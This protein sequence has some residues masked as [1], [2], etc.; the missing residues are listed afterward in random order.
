MNCILADFYFP[1]HIQDLIYV[2]NVLFLT[3]CTFT[4]NYSS[5]PL[6]YFRISKKWKFGSGRKINSETTCK[7]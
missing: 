6:Q 1:F 4:Y 2:F 5:A 3:E 7:S